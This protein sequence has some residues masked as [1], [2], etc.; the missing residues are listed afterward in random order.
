MT[1]TK[2]TI[3]ILDETLRLRTFTIQVFKLVKGHL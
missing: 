2:I 1:C 3:T